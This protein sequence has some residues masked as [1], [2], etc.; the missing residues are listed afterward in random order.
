[1]VHYHKVPLKLH[2]TPST[3]KRGRVRTW[4]KTHPLPPP[5]ALM[6]RVNG[7]QTQLLSDEKWGNFFKRKNFFHHYP[8]P[9]TLFSSIGSIFLIN[10]FFMVITIKWNYLSMTEPLQLIE[11]SCLKHL[12]IPDMVQTNSKKSEYFLGR[13][14]TSPAVAIKKAHLISRIN[15]LKGFSCYSETLTLANFLETS[16]YKE[17]HYSHM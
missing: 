6:K 14:W 16:L 4:R 10:C 2:S 1:M 7:G 12:T 15:P 3:R 13:R 9:P 11:T 5:C 8:T 17:S